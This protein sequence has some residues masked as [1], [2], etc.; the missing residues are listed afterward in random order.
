[1]KAF[2]F[3]SFCRHWGRHPADAA[4]P[5]DVV[6]LPAGQVQRVTQFIARSRAFLKTESEGFVYYRRQTKFAKVMFSQVSVC[7]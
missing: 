2:M 3:A 1:M 4:L 7:P 5:H 6:R